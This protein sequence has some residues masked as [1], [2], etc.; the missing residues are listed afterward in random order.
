MQSNNFEKLNGKNL[1]IAIVQAR[2]NREITNGLKLGAI[3]A[4]KEAG[5]E[6]DNIEFFKVPGAVEIPLVCKRLSQIKKFDGIITLGAIIKGE[7]AHFDY[8]AKMSSDGIMS[9]ML[10]ENFPITYGIITTY[11]LEQA[12]KR[13]SNNKTNKGYEAAMA[14][15]ELILTIKKCV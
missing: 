9:V 5:I 11:N 2:F 3:Q 6:N 4:L 13:S 8:I 12:K 7:T 1:K 14:L 10:E 15:I